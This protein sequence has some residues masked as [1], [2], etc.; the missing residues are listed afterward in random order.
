M[1]VGGSVGHELKRKS[2]PKFRVFTNLYHD[3][4]QCPVTL[5]QHLAHTSPKCLTILYLHAAH[6]NQEKL[7]TIQELNLRNLTTTSTVHKKQ[8]QPQVFISSLQPCVDP[9]SLPK[10]IVQADLA[11]VSNHTVSWTD[12]SGG[13]GG[14]E[15]GG[16][17]PAAPYKSEEAEAAVDEALGTLSVAVSAMKTAARGRPRAVAAIWATLV[18]RP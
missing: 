17:P 6:R 10:S 2:K 1:A 4:R 12:A 15:G 7:S 13:V 18:W 11:V 16:V 5:L 14:G 3:T 9:G 8:I